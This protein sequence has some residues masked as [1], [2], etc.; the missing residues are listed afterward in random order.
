MSATRRD[1]AVEHQDHVYY[2]PTRDSPSIAARLSA[3][4]LPYHLRY[5]TVHREGLGGLGEAAERARVRDQRRV[6]GT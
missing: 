5:H 3:C 1:R 4:G 2:M 6:V